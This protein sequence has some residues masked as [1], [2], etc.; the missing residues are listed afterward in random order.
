MA[1]IFG[2]FKLA[3]NFS[4]ERKMADVWNT[5][6]PNPN[7]QVAYDYTETKSFQILATEFLNLMRAMQM[8]WATL[9]RR[10]IENHV[11]CSLSYLCSSTPQGTRLGPQTWE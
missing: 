8:Q 5:A 1:R 11:S 3:P 7:N 9:L 6:Q 10:E 4:L 2:W